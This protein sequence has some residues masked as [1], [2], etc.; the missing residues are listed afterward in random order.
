MTTLLIKMDDVGSTPIEM[1]GATSMRYAAMRAAE[2]LGYDP[3]GADWRLLDG[4]T[5]LPIP[6][7]ELAVEHDGKLFILATAQPYR[8]ARGRRE[9]G[10]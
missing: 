3:M 4:T 1:P 5:E 8:R 2:E 10:A 7:D 6:E 9:E